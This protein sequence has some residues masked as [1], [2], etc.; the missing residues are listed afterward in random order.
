MN[1][2]RLQE[3]LFDNVQFDKNELEDKE[4]GICPLVPHDGKKHSMEITKDNKTRS[5]TK[6]ECKSMQ[7]ALKQ[8]KPRTWK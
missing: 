5:K 3:E 7:H 1:G 6:T 2:K 8:T 4:T